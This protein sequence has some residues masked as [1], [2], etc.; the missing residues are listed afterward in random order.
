[1]ATSP[2][3]FRGQGPAAAGVSTRWRTEAVDAETAARL[4]AAGR[5]DDPADYEADPGL[6]DA[7]NVALL[8]GRPLLLTGRP[9]TGKSQLADRVAW[10]F[11]LAPVLRFEAQSISEAKDLFYGFDFVGR[12]AAAQ[13]TIGSA[14]AARW[15]TLRALGKAVLYSL[16]MS[17]QPDAHGGVALDPPHPAPATGRASVV[18]IDEID[19]ASRDF[20]N[21]L[22][23]AMDRLA[24]D[25]PEL[26][27]LRFEA[28]RDPRTRP[29]VV[30]TSNSERELPEPFLRRCVYYN[31]PDPGPRQL[32]RIVAARVLNKRQGAGGGGGGAAA[33]GTSLPPLFDELVQCFVDYRDQGARR[34]VY[35]PGTSEL[36]DL[37]RVVAGSEDVRETEPLAHPPNLGRARHA[38]AAVAKGKGDGDEFLRHLDTWRPQ[39]A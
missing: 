9:G 5:M 18:L 27:S 22:L 38:V 28:S 17:S 34:V 35:T 1:M 2:L 12:M 21:D 36:I 4:M 32:R 3:L 6:V 25:I 30:I 20:P 19:K 23:N 7:V 15:I 13:A 24:F 16:P 33:E 39:R 26:G 29:V 14:D 37:A 31:I 10:E 8:L 11:G